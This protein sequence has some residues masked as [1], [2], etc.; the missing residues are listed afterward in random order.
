MKRPIQKLLKRL[1]TFLN[2][3]QQAKYQLNSSIH[4]GDT[5]DFRIP[6]PKRPPPFLTTPTENY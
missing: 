3:Y 1:L 6:E 2:L 4:S 5:A